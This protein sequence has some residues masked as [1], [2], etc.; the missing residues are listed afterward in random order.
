LTTVDTTVDGDARFPQMNDAQWRETAREPH[1]A[2]A[3]HAHPF[4]FTLL[5]RSTSNRG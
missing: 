1:P 3:R 5:E 4:I 2:D